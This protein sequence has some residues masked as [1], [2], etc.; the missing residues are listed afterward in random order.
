MVKTRTIDVGKKFLFKCWLPNVSGRL[1]F[2]KFGYTAVSGM[3]FNLN[4]TDNRSRILISVQ[5]RSSTDTVLPVG[6]PSRFKL[7]SLA[8]YLYYICVATSELDGESRA[9]ESLRGKIYILRDRELWIKE[10]RPKLKSLSARVATEYD[11]LDEESLTVFSK[12]DLDLIRQTAQACSVFNIEFITSRTGIT[13]FETPE[14]FIINEDAPAQ[15]END[16]RLDYRIKA[17]AAQCYY[18]LRDIAHKHQHHAP[19]SDTIIDIYP[20]TDE[21]DNGWH[22]QILY[23]MYRRIIA[24]KRVRDTG[25]YLDSLGILG[26]AN[27]FEEI[28]KEKYIETSSEKAPKSKSADFEDLP[29]FYKESLRE[30]IQSTHNREMI[31]YQREN[32]RGD[33]LRNWALGIIGT[34]VAFGGL[35]QL[36]ERDGILHGTRVAWELVCVS[37][38]LL[39]HPVESIVLIVGI[40]FAAASFTDHF[41]TQRQNYIRNLARLLLSR[42]KF[43]SSLISFVLSVVFIAVAL[44]ILILRF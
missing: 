41:R 7:F 9:L 43:W 26:Y 10:L 6:N 15:Y 3:R 42:S 16:Q 18:F 20:V 24:L 17:I 14:E 23:S 34:I 36:A 2:S 30:S 1:S 33:F 37:E 28:C 5:K 13:S 44:A 8:N 31:R 27:T 38:F 22:L 19:S 25:S 39:K 29:I 21:S 11:S 32:W 40:V 4:A 35:L 12:D